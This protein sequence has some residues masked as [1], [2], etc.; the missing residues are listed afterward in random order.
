MRSG[1]VLVLP[2]LAEGRGLVLVEAMAEGLP[3]VASDIPGPRELVLPGRTGFLFPPGDATAL[4]ECLWRLADP[5]V[6]SRLGEGG[7]AFV[8]EQGLTVDA[9]ARNHVAMYC[10]L[11][12][13]PR[14]FQGRGARRDRAAT[15]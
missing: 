2:S 9:S 10:A 5:S 1:H 13:T 14:R 3:I 11:E 6:R 4:A 12:A 8:D 7:R 15:S